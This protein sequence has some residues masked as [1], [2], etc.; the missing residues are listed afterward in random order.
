MLNVRFINNKILYIKDYVVDNK[1]DILVIIEIWF[2]FDDD[3]YFIICDI[4]L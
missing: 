4:C 3:C 2:K 1:I